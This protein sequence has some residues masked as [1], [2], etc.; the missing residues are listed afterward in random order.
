MKPDLNLHLHTN[1]A[2]GQSIDFHKEFMQAFGK[3]IRAACAD[4]PPDF[5]DNKKPATVLQ[6]RPARRPVS[7]SVSPTTTE[8]QSCSNVICP[9]PNSAG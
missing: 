1:I 9:N 2:P 6:F 5:T 7:T 3:D 4:V 8:D